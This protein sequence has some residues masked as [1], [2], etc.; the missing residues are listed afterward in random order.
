[1]RHKCDRILDAL[2]WKLYIFFK[3]NLAM[4]DFIIVIFYRNGIFLIFSN[5]FLLKENV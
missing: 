5:Q 1:M 4:P 2:T 3:T